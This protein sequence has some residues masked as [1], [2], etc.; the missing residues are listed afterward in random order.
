MRVFHATKTYA[1]Y[2]G[3]VKEK[4]ILLGRNV[5]ATEAFAHVS[6][7]PFL[8]G[9]YALDV[10]GE[11]TNRAWILECEISDTTPLED[12]PADE[13]GED[14]NGGWRVSRI[15]IEVDAIVRVTFVRNV[16]EY[17]GGD[18]SYAHVIFEGS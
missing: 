11:D 17:E 3:I 4:K 15:P 6:L 14:Y 10:I 9:S 5:T 16:Q 8:P 2:Q 13:A 1:G 18:V 7:N 12:D